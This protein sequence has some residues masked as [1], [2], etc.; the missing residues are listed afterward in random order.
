MNELSS[1]KGIGS[2]TI[3]KLNKLDIYSIDDLVDYYPYRYERIKRSVAGK[4]IGGAKAPPVRSKEN[5]LNVCPLLLYTISCK[6][7][8]GRLGEKQKNGKGFR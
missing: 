5:E 3:N 1:I 6:G 7:S 2:S 8:R 4:K